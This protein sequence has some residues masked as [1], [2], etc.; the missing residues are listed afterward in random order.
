MGGLQGRGR[1]QTGA[2]SGEGSDFG[3]GSDSRARA[4]SDS[5]AG[6]DSGA[7]SDS[8][9]PELQTPKISPFYCDHMWL[10]GSKQANVAHRLCPDHL[11]QF[12]P[13]CGP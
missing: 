6:L 13:I 12:S 4:G 3:E 9:R 10:H 7:G 5:G 1:L 8:G 11:H 2:D